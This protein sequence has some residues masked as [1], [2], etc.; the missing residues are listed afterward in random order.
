MLQCVAVR[1]SVLQCVAVRC[2]MLRRVSQRVAWY[3]IVLH[4]V[5]VCCSVLQCVLHSFEYETDTVRVVS[6]PNFSKFTPLS[7]YPVKCL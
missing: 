7:I 6:D 2:N 5:A 3:C 4:C 1:C